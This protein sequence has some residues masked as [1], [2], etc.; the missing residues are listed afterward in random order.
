[1]TASYLENLLQQRLAERHA[2]H[3]YRSR[4]VLASAQQ[5]RVVAD[6]KPFLSFCSNDYLGLAS[7]PRLVRALQQGAERWGV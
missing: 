7:D 5:A 2:Q 6:G 3:R 4:S 1:M